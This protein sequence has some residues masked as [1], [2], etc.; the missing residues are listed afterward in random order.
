MTIYAAEPGSSTEQN[1]RLLSAWW[2]TVAQP[3]EANRLR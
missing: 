1:L 2:A 3:D